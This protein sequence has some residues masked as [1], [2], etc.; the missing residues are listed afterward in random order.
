MNNSQE[1]LRNSLNELKSQRDKAQKEVL[2]YD[3]AITRLEGVLIDIGEITPAQILAEKPKVAKQPKEK[4]RKQQRYYSSK[5]TENSVRD[6]IIELTKNPPEPYKGI[7]KLKEGFFTSVSVADI[8]GIHKSESSAIKIILEKFVD[9]GILEYDK[10]KN[11][12]QYRYIPPAETGPGD[13][14]IAQSK[15]NIPGISAGFAADSGI[16]TSRGNTIPGIGVSK[17]H[18]RDKDVQKLIRV[19]EQQGY[20]AEVKGSN[21]ILVSDGNGRSTTISATSNSS[22]LLDKVRTDLRNIGVKV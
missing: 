18:T 4:T 10:Y 6:A 15:L 16:R 7:F 1:I 8:I 19:A 12:R 13:A 22:R 14:A 20:L 3:S 17:I 5:I 21:H 2:Q 9:K 11:G